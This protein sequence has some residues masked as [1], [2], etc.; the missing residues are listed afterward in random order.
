[1]LFCQAMN[2]TQSTDWD[3]INDYLHTIK[4]VQ[5]I[6]STYS[7]NG[8]PMLSTSEFVVQIVDGA[9]KVITVVKS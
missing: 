4:D 1:M 9:S 7:Y 6:A 2:E 5:G 3:T 8:T